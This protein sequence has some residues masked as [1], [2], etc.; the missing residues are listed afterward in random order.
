MKPGRDTAKPRPGLD[1][2]FLFAAFQEPF[3]GNFKKPRISVKL[4]E[5][6]LARTLQSKSPLV[7]E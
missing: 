5:S 4:L 7:L 6:V 1:V 3:A 2:K